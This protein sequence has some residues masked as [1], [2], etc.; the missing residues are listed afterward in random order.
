MFSSYEKPHTSSPDFFSQMWPQRYFSVGRNKSYGSSPP[1]S[2]I[3][4]FVVQIEG[5]VLCKTQRHS[6]AR[7]RMS[8]TALLAARAR[9]T[10]HPPTSSSCSYAR[11]FAHTPAACHHHGIRHGAGLPTTTTTWYRMGDARGAPRGWS[12]GRGGR[13]DRLAAT[14][15]DDG[16]MDDT[17]SSSSS[18]AWW[19][20]LRE[21]H[22]LVFNAE[23]E[24]EAIYT[25][26]RR[27]GEFA[28]NDFVAFESMQDA[29]RASVRVSDQLGEMPV[30]DSVDP[31]WGGFCNVLLGGVGGS[32]ETATGRRLPRASRGAPSHTQLYF[33]YFPISCFFFQLELHLEGGELGMC[34]FDDP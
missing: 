9:A 16:E 13:S 22:I 23:T 29:L 3:S 10:P 6:P 11:R 20:L 17:P 12:R 26:S 5:G 33:Y 15:D 34:R 14:G 31:R 8:T 2:S 27:S 21:V 30:V 24:R 19:E 25:T 28:A 18:S 32:V 1:P 7:F 4:F